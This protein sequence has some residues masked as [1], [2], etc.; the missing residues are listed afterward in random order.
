M[1]HAQSEANAHL[2]HM[3]LPEMEDFLK[4]VKAEINNRKER[5]RLE[6]HLKTFKPSM[7]VKNGDWFGAIKHLSLNR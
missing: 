5:K 7:P 3:S 4:I 1:T 6:Q 2:V